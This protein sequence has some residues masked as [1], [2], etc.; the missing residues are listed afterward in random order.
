MKRVFADYAY[1]SGP[2]QGCWWDETCDLPLQPSLAGAQK[3]DVAVIGAGFTGLSAAY[4]L[5]R[6][7]A[8]VA[9]LDA[10]GPGWGASGRNGG[11]CCLGG[12]KADDAYLDRQFGK[13]GRLDY[14]AAERATVELVD[15]LISELRLDVDKHSQGETELAHRF[16][17]LEGFKRRVPAIVENYG[18]EPHI[19]EARDLARAGFGGR[20]HGALTTPIGFALNPRKYLRG[21]VLAANAAGARLFNGSAVE[22]LETGATSVTLIT[23]HGTLQAD[24]VVI[25]TNGYSSDDLPD[26]LNG[27][28][29]PAQ[30]S[31]LVTQPLS[32]G[33]LDAQGWST[34]QMSYDSRNLLH[35][36]RLMPDR[37]FLFGMRG[38][39]LSGID[40]EQKARMR[41]RCDF[42]QMFPAWSAVASDHSWSGMVCL[43]RNKLP[44][45]GQVPGQSRLWAGLCYHGNGVAMGTL[46][47]RILADLILGRETPVFPKAMQRPLGRFP[48]GRLRRVLMPPLYAYLSWRDRS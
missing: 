20:F 18:V 34:S 36:F 39:L 15:T 24:Q 29:M 4:H 28:Y 31:V 45:V 25:A 16:G 11:F 19:I 47:G 3:A 23:D 44:F 33:D 9:V 17:D 46:S 5:A 14:R 21:L 7:G 32:Q 12:S 38:G 42:E 40:A 6:V 48:M 35:Y 10:H 22:A 8:T 43:A 13:P 26:W 27:R 41:L 1:G 30:S 37:R 2:R